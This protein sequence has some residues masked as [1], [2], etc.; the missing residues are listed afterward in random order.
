MIGM[1]T[2]DPNINPIAFIPSD[3]A[4]D[5]IYPRS[6]FQIVDSAFSVNFPDLREDARQHYSRKHGL[7]GKTTAFRGYAG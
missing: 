5:D 7:D 3:K 4:I 2:H 1:G 6:S